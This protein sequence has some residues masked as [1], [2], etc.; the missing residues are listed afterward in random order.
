MST[1]AAVGPSD[2]LQVVAV[3]VVPV[4]AAPAVVVVDAAG[5]FVR[6]VGPKR[7][8]PR[9]NVLEDPI[10]LH[11]ADEEGVVLDCEVLVGE[12]VGQGDAVVELDIQKGPN[13]TGAGRPSTSAS[14]VADARGSRAWTMVWFSSMD[15]VLLHAG[16]PAEPRLACGD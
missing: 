15:I 3:G 10:E 14:W 12:D 11:F 1:A 8:P 5:L 7:Q 6:R 13:L 9:L 16:S 4:D 2:D